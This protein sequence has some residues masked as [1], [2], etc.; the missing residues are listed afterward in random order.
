MRF[1]SVSYASAALATD[2]KARAASL[3]LI[4]T[5]QHTSPAQPRDVVENTAASKTDNS[6]K[7]AIMTNLP[8]MPALLQAV[9]LDKHCS[10]ERH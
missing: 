10:L 6:L 3:A 9:E 5:K 2:A 7:P 4:S 1:C 8:A